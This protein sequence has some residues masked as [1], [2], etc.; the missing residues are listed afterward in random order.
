MSAFNWLNNFC[1]SPND[2]LINYNK[3]GQQFLEHYYKLFDY[4]W[5]LLYTC[6]NANA[7]MTF[8]NE[9]YFGGNS[10]KNKYELLNLNNPKHNSYSYNV[11]PVG[12]NKISIMVIGSL[13]NSSKYL[14]TTFAQQTK[15]FNYVE[16][17]VI[18][19]ENNRWFIQSHIF[20]L[21][22]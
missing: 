16:S 10:I 14:W 18:M 5:K 6:Y 1:S 8:Q 13:T 12:K 7:T 17:F 4:N 20:R 2:S 19:N 11:Q 21:L 15:T 3:I 22:C 9:E